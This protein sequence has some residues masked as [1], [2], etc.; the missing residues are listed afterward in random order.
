MLNYYGLGGSSAQWFWGAL[1]YEKTSQDGAGH[2]RWGKR[3][4]L[5]QRRETHH[6]YWPHSQW[7]PLTGVGEEGKEAGTFS[8]SVGSEYTC[9]H[10]MEKASTSGETAVGEK[11][12]GL[13]KQPG[14]NN[15]HWAGTPSSLPA[16]WN[17]WVPKWSWIKPCQKTWMFWCQWIRK[18]LSLC[19][20]QN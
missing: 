5:K 13:R 15:P 14:L 11:T 7:F 8:W 6:S 17:R 4:D 16:I 10:G 3:K 2:Q 12:S 18:M 9:Q 1:S 19:Y 20:C